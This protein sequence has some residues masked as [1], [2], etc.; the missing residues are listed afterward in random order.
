MWRS[1]GL[2]AVVALG[3]VAAPC[4]DRAGLEEFEKRAVKAGDREFS[5][6]FKLPFGGTERPAIVFT[7]ETGRPWE[8][9]LPGTLIRRGV[10][11]FVLLPQEPEPSLTAALNWIRRNS[12]ELGV[13]AR[14][15]ALIRADSPAPDAA[16]GAELPAVALSR[17]QASIEVIDR[18]LAELKWVLAR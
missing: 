4:W 16:E 5:L 11:V 13:D 12:R 15:I 14:K 18:F 2:T 3:A 6:C 10:V 1:L 8:P 7:P 17:T 9:K